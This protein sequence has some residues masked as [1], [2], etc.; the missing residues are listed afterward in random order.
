MGDRLAKQAEDNESQSQQRQQ[1][2]QQQQPVFGARDEIGATDRQIRG[3][4]VAGGM[5]GAVLAGPVGAVIGAAG[6]AYA[7]AKR[8]CEIGEAARTT[9]DTVADKS[10]FF[11]Q[12]ET[13]NRTLQEC[14]FRG[15]ERRKQQ[16]QQQQQNVTGIGQEENEEEMV[17]SE[18]QTQAPLRLRG[19]M[20]EGIGRTK[21]SLVHG[22]TRAN[23]SVRN[24]VQNCTTKVSQMKE[25]LGNRMRLKRR[26]RPSVNLAEENKEDETEYYDCK[27][28]KD[29]HTFDWRCTEDDEFQDA[30]EQFAIEQEMIT[31]RSKDQH[32]TSSSTE[33]VPTRRDMIA[34]V[35]L[36]D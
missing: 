7:A 19:K 5:A 3:A 6:A 22:A 4:A 33:I 23:Q 34:Q 28:N 31:N 11:L 2:Q 30:K 35:L 12:N 9:G 27:P 17:Q 21:D 24:G 36:S 18:S 10:D 8:E 14:S 25:T 16:Q 29:E 32:V 13:V 1:Q 20:S 15:R 26:G